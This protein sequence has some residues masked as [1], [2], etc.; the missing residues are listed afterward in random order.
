VGEHTRKRQRNDYENH[1]KEDDAGGGG[2]EGVKIV[3]GKN[4]NAK[5]KEIS[6]LSQSN[7][8]VISEN[9]YLIRYVCEVVMW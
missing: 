4:E 6:S 5:N 1:Q 8:T 7:F 2:G 9:S 3:E